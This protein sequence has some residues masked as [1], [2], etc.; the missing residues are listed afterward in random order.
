ML[1][2]QMDTDVQ[3]WAGERGGSLP[4]PGLLQP[5]QVQERCPGWLLSNIV[6]GALRV[7]WLTASMPLLFLLFWGLWNFVSAP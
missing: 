3:S 1:F 7:C 4:P 6:L 2:S 5:P